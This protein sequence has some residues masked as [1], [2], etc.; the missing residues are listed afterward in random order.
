MPLSVREIIEIKE[1]WSYFCVLNFYYVDIFLYYLIYLFNE[2]CNTV[3]VTLTYFSCQLPVKVC[4]A[5][6]NMNDSLAG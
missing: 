4:V 5:P 2:S 1:L 3:A 6:L